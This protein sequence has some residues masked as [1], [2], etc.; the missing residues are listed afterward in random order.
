MKKN[1][2]ALTLA[3]VTVRAMAAQ[4]AGAPPPDLSDYLSPP[5]VNHHG[6]SD[7]LWQMLNDAGQTAGF[8]GGKAQRAWELRQALDAQDA[9]LNRLYTFAPLISHQGWL[10]PVIVQATSLAHITGEQIRTASRVYTIL[11]PERFVSNPP[12][13]R[14]Y[15]LAGLQVSRDIPADIRP[16]NS[17]E[18]TVWR[19]AVERGWQEGRD[20]AD[21][22][23]R[24]NFSRL[25][26]D[27]TG[28]V[29][30][31]TLLKQGMITPPVVSEQLQTVTGK[32][33]SMTLGDR[34]RDLRRHARFELDK[35]RWKP[36][37]RTP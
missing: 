13:W 20:S 19:A 36:S 15:L 7:T 11:V 17:D 23:L 28:M 14:Q 3:L 16:K 26:R 24:S 12:G 1:L 5:V 34:V 10:P 2:L 25:T 31:S 9:M 6:L 4:D 33:D 32:P 21:D 27:Y 37:V 8:R 35:K 22:T 30:Y 29:R 18:M